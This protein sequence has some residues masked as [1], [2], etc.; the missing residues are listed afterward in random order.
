MNHTNLTFTDATIL[1]DG[2]AY[3]GC[4]FIRCKMVYTGVGTVSLSG[5]SMHECSWSFTGPAAN[6]MGFLKALY[7]GGGKETVERTLD[8]IRGKP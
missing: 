7:T 4:T 3:K 5:N 8:A 2:H 1:I 6:T